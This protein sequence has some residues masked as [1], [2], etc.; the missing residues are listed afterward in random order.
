IEPGGMAEF[1]RVPATNLR[2]DALKLPSSL[3]FEDGALIE[4]TACV[5]KSLRKAGFKPDDRVL[6]IGLG[7]M[8]QMHILMARESGARQII[9][10]D[11]VP[12]RL[13]KAMEFGADEVVNVEEEDLLEKAKDLTCGQLADLVIVGP[14]STSAMKTGISCA[15]K[16][17]TV[18]F[19]TP[20]PVEE[21]LEI[22]PHDLYF[23]EIDLLFSYSS[24]PND[25]QQALTLIEQGVVNAEKLVTHR[26]PIDNVAEAFE[27]ATRANDSL[28]TV[29]ISD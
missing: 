5:V 7:A 4:P 20:S 2:G 15:G 18:L 13:S 12:Y 21:L 6:V 24:G 14:G 8:G 22:N 25:T 1:F 29:V 3:S 19:F 9:G 11:L 23:N 28:K 16:G 26:F 17:G 27:I 10:A